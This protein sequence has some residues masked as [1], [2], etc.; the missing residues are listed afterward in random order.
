MVIIH[1]QL[2]TA[3]WEY[4]FHRNSFSIYS[5]MTIA[6][7][8]IASIDLYSFSMGLSPCFDG[9]YKGCSNLV[10]QVFTRRKR[11]GHYDV[12]PNYVFD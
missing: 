7:A 1:P 9:I 10:A 12:I 2:V 4:L 8:V 6:S 3:I 5:D 11:E